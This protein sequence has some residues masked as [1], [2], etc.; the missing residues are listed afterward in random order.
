MIRIFKVTLLITCLLAQF[1]EE[2]LVALLR[3]QRHNI[4]FMEYTP[5]QRQDIAKAIVNVLKV[6]NSNKIW[7][8]E[9]AK[10]KFHDI[11]RDPLATAQDIAKIAA[12][13]S[14][15]EF[16][17]RL[18]ALFM[19]LKD[20]HTLYKLPGPHSCYSAAQAISFS[21][22]GGEKKQR[23]IVSEFIKRQ[24]VLDLSPNVSKISVGDELVSVEN[25]SIENYFEKY[26]NVVGGANDGASQRALLLFMSVRDGKQNRM[27]DV[28]QVQYELRSYKTGEMYNVT[29]PWVTLAIDSCYNEWTRASRSLES[30]PAARTSEPK[31]SKTT[32]LQSHSDK[33]LLFQDNF[34]GDLAPKGLKI[35]DTLDPT[36]KFGIWRPE[37]DN[38]GVIIL[39]SFYP[40]SKDAISLTAQIRDL[41]VKKNN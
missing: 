22:I 25:L 21:V 15:D 35:T 6:C 40:S 37:T 12:S 7:V 27:P 36:L 18:S 28:D 11:D 1:G 3:D 5:R 13:L 34:I 38:V 41:L 33:L 16:H 17:S 30:F 4:D 20:G 31:F 10:Q 39:K 9:A 32:I 24:K 23:I 29:L 2:P 26:K 19:S 14:D 8:N